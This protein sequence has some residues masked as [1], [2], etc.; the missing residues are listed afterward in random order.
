MNLFIS[1]QV[2]TKLG[3]EEVV[4]PKWA[5]KTKGKNNDNTPHHLRKTPFLVDLG[6]APD[7]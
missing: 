3:I 4:K 6:L 7:L 2:G 1:F 5:W